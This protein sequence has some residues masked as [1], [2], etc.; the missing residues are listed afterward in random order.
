[1]NVRP[2]LGYSKAF[3]HCIEN[4]LVGLVHDDPVDLLLRDLRIVQSL[5]DHCRHGPHS[6]LEHLLAVHRNVVEACGLAGVLRTRLVARPAETR[7]E[8]L[9]ALAV[10][11]HSMAQQTAGLPRRPLQHHSAAAVPE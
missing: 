7:V 9:E 11:V 6:E 10:T 8:V 2:Y 1:M 4:S 3:L 5:L